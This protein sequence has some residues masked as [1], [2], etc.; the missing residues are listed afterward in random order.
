MSH[1]GWISLSFEGY[2]LL[3][4]ASGDGETEGATDRDGGSRVIPVGARWDD[5]V[6]ADVTAVEAE[7]VEVEVTVRVVEA[8]NHV[9]NVLVETDGAARLVQQVAAEVTETRD[10]LAVDDGLDLNLTDGLGDDTL[11][12]FAKDSQL[13]LDNLDGLIVADNVLLLD[14]NDLVAKAT[15]VVDA[16]EVVKVGER[17]KSTPVVEGNGGRAQVTRLEGSWRSQSGTG[18]SDGGR[19]G[20]DGL[21]EHFD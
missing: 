8:A 16:I 19:N 13:L 3:D 17:A 11:G 14:F 21:G 6:G 18:N 1:R 9:G 20:H 15:E 12:E 10:K 4:G 5:E 7:V 2:V